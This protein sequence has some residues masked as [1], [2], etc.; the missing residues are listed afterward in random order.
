M[1]LLVLVV[2]QA[3]EVYLETRLWSMD[4]QGN[5]GPQDYQVYRA[6]QG[7]MEP[8]DD[9]DPLVAKVTEEIL[10]TMVDVVLLESRER[11]VFQDQ[12]VQEVNLDRRDHL[13]PQV[14]LVVQLKAKLYLVLQ[15]P[16]VRWD[17]LDPVGNLE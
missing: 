10:V 15:G 17:L 12:W 8:Q 7:M 2:N 11:T 4:P 1:D 5:K 14:Y 13:E 6:H 9:V 16:L 3:L